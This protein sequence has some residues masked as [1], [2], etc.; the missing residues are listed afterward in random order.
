MHPLI[1][2]WWC[3]TDPN[4]VFNYPFRCFMVKNLVKEIKVTKR[5]KEKEVMCAEL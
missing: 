3:K 1:M 5:E 4:A 2:I